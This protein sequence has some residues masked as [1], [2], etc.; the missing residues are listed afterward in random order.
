MNLKRWTSWHRIGIEPLT[1]S[2]RVIGNN[3]EMFSN[4]SFAVFPPGSAKDQSNFMNIGF[5]G[6]VRP[7][8]RL[9]V[10]LTLLA[11]LSAP[12]FGQ[13]WTPLANTILQN[14]CASQS[15]G[16]NI[17]CEG[18]VYAWSSAVADTARNRLIIWGGGHADYLGNEVY[19]LYP[20]AGQTLPGTTTVNANGV[21]CTSNTSPAI[22]RLNNYTLPNNNACY[23]NWSSSGCLGTY[24]ETIGGSSSTQGAPNAPNSRHTYNGLV[25]DS[26][27][28]IL[29]SF[30]GFPSVSSGWSGAIWALNLSGLASNPNGANWTQMDLTATVAGANGNPAN[31][32][33]VYK[34]GAMGSNPPI[35]VYDPSGDIFYLMTSSGYIWSYKYSTNAITFLAR[36]NG[37]VASGSTAV[38]YPP[39]KTIYF[40]GDDNE[41]TEPVGTPGTPHIFQMSYASGSNWT[42]TEITSSTTGCSNL[43]GHMMP[44]LTY[45]SATQKI[46]GWPDF[47]NIA[48]VFDPSTNTCT[49]T[50][51]GGADGNVSSCGAGTS[52]S[53][54]P[55]DGSST[56]TYGRFQYFPSQNQFVLLNSSG[57][58]GYTMSLAGASS[59]SSA[60]AI[61]TSSLPS[62]QTG[63]I[64]SYTVTTSGCN[65]PT[66][67]ISSGTL[68]SGLTLNASTGGITGSATTAG[69]YPFTVAV[70]ASPNNA[71]QPLS[72]TVAAPGSSLPTIS[73]FTATP[74]SITSGQA[75]TLSW[76]SPGATS[77]SISPGAFSS[78]S[79][80]GSTS[81]S[82]AATTTY[83]LTATN[84]A[85]SVSSN[86]TATVG[87]SVPP[88]SIT[89]NTITITNAGAAASNYPVQ[90]G[91]PFVQ[92][93][94]PN[95]QLPQ[96][97][98][99]GN[100]LPTQVDV[101]NR[102]PDGSLKHAV[103]SFLLPTF[104]AGQAYTITFSPGSTVGNTPLTQAQM[105][106]AGF[107]FDAQIQ[108]TGG[109]TTKTATARTM[110]TNGDYTV[111]ASGPIA[112]TIILANH[113]QGTTCGG[114]AASKYDFGF[115]SY[116]AFRPEFEATFWP[117]TNQVFVRF[118]GEIAD[119]EQLE[120]VVVNNLVLTLG[121]SGAST[122]Y[123]LPASLSPL[124][125]GALTR[126][127][128][129][130]WVNGTPPPAGY[131]HN[132]AYL[133]ATK[134]VPNYDPGRAIPAAQISKAWSTWQSLATADPYDPAD[135]TQAQRAPGGR[136][137][138][139]DEIGPYTG[140]EVMWLYSGDSRAQQMAIRYAELASAWP[141]HWREG[142]SGKFIDRSQ[143]ISG[144]GHWMSPSTRPTYCIGCGNTFFNYSGIAGADVVTPV[145]STNYG[146]VSGGSTGWCPN[147]AHE[148]DWTPVYLLTGDYYFLE[149]NWAWASYTTLDV[150]G[151]RHDYPGRGPTGVEGQIPGNAVWGEQIRGSGWGFRNRAEI[152]M[153]SPDGTPE[154]ALYRLL[155]LDMLA[156]SE[157]ERNI[158]GN[159][160]NDTT[161]CWTIS[162]TTTC[163]NAIW[164]WG[165]Q[166]AAAN[167]CTSN[168]SSVGLW[169]ASPVAGV[170]LGVP[171]SIHFWT[172]EAYPG[173][174]NYPVDTTQQSSVGCTEHFMVHYMIYALG[175]AKDLGFAAN[176]L[177]AWIGSYV[178]NDVVSG[179]NP[180]LASSYGTVTVQSN[181]Q[182]YTTYTGI[183]SAI[184]SSTGT[185]CVTGG[186]STNAQ[187][188][189]GFERP[190]NEFACSL[191][192]TGD[193]NCSGAYE[194]GLALSQV[195]DQTNGAAAWNWIYTNAM[196]NAAVNFDP[197]WNI[198]ARA[199]SS[200]SSGTSPT[201]SA[202]PCD[203]NADGV[204]NVADVMIAINQALGT[205]AC[206]NAALQGNGQC[207]VVDVQRVINA[208]LGL[209]CRTGQ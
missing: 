197:K 64:Y 20:F 179:P 23:P 88:P 57:T 137:Y 118:I 25:Y 96:A 63:T 105:L 93:E 85:G 128:Q 95:G 123:T 34:L 176:P 42:P 98:S 44:G 94:I 168:P 121:N 151:A 16:G 21:V 138:P 202:S 45:D 12:A 101:K 40:I 80:S 155:T 115:D 194:L 67:S 2:R 69:T 173:A 184:C 116:C 200:S 58:V 18:V 114:K 170:N 73:S 4:H 97:F 167:Y 171:T 124:T 62:T 35:A 133:A 81:V 160:Q 196:T 55:R 41:G 7:Q 122:V 82:P 159:F 156:A 147:V 1:I 154:Q 198:I 157:G 193:G 9:A 106:T 36:G 49:A 75:A 79:A 68:P 190:L 150:D 207:N 61:T 72:I 39:T 131:N 111:W 43:A 201:T 14:V 130:Y 152:A 3:K 51:F 143:T 78:S 169:C 24:T 165:H 204:V 6:R 148:P 103:L 192:A 161:D 107:N 129:T 140:P 162:S 117:A 89:A 84:S 120:N 77:I 32:P 56:G 47:G 65:S 146:C 195:A 113:A 189:L 38:L 132:L 31:P 208:S 163:E 126:W 19:A 139:A 52:Q 199:S 30:G 144:I 71:S 112:T 206:T 166:F 27:A 182:Y 149:E 203:L 83:T 70:T 185:G 15:P 135:Y 177:L 54:C 28:D 10:Q 60:C 110:L 136:N 26:A 109:A 145:G 99:G 17:G 180:Y 53:D 174:C 48:Y 76:V 86:A 46:V 119:T 191:E 87:A 13:G 102:W 178:I 164:T 134:L 188:T 186:A 91:R 141:V 74:A 59:S 158:T 153:A 181:G 172:P 104:S 100:A 125:M 8:M 92:G 187:T 5:D 108:L 127:T 22:C 37:A 183:Q 205:A 142:K 90:I 33:S 209:S 66:F 175:R 11:L 29:L 50:S